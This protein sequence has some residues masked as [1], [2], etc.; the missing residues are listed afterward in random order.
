MSAWDRQPKEPPKAYLHFTVYRDLGPQRTLGKASGICGITEGSLQQESHTWNW[1][2]RCDQW[3]AHVQA[4]HD[5][6][7]VTEAAK[8]GRERAQAFTKLLGKCLEALEKVDV[9]E[10][11]L[12]KIASALKVAS[13]GMRLEEG[14]ETQ[15]V[16]MEVADARTLISQLPAEVRREVIRALAEHAAAER[17]SVVAGGVPLG[18]G[19]DQSN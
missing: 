13:E 18:L 3:D 6:A 9:S 16:S 4:I 12:E 19:A 7:F 1:V 11:P 8:R 5:R 14:L 15:R 2:G 10:V 17:S